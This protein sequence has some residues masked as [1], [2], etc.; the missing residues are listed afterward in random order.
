MLLSANKSLKDQDAEFRAS[1][2]GKDQVGVENELI[3]TK[4]GVFIL[5]TPTHGTPQMISEDGKIPAGL[6]PAERLGSYD[7]SVKPR[8][9]T[10]HQM[11]L[12]GINAIYIRHQLHRPHVDNPLQIVDETHY[13]NLLEKHKQKIVEKVI[14]ENLFKMIAKNDMPAAF[15]Y[16]IPQGSDKPEFAAV[17]GKQINSLI[18][19]KLTD[20]GVYYNRE[21]DLANVNNMLSQLGLKSVKDLLQVQDLQIDSR[22]G[23]IK[24]NGKRRSARLLAHHG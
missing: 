16:Y 9:Q 1:I 18:G 23:S 2:V 5:F 19:N 12:S 17:F 14:E 10:T 7:T 3:I 24:E 21:Q 13:I 15:Y 20:P 11:P 22:L 6:I 8:V 4:N